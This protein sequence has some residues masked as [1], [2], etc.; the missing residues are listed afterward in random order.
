MYSTSI[1]AISF[2]GKQYASKIQI[3]SLTEAEF[4]TI[5]ELA[6]TQYGQIVRHLI[7]LKVQASPLQKYTFSDSALINVQSLD[8]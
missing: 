8:W 4:N 2:A 3:Q 1:I 6:S 5:M 7:N